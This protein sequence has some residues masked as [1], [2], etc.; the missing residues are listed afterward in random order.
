MYRVGFGYDS[1]RLVKGRKLILG[2]IEVPFEKGCLGHSDGDA[3]IHSICDSIIG[4][5]ALKDIGY[6]FP[7]TSDDYKDID[8]RILLKKTIELARLNGWDVENLDTTVCLEKPKLKDFIPTMVD[9]LAQIMEIDI[10]QI[11]IKATTNEKM[12]FVGRHEGIAVYAVCLLSK[13]P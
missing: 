9:V 10:S 7:D 3:L 12:G 1:H 13:L 6:H 5:A 11:N 4:A 2:G 8:S